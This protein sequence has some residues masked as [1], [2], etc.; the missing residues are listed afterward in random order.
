MRRG[1]A[2]LALAFLAGCGSSGSE[3]AKAAQELAPKPP[4][5]EQK[6]Q[7]ERLRTQF[8]QGGASRP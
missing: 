8:P 4:T 2:L 6:A 3:E 7:L 5:A 1:L